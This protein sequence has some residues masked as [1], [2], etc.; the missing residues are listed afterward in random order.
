MN[1]LIVRLLTLFIL[2]ILVVFSFTPIP[3]T[4]LIMLYVVLFRPRWFK[5][6]VDLI[7]AEARKTGQDRTGTTV[8]SKSTLE[9]KP[10]GARHPPSSQGTDF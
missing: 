7:Y 1:P 5:H 2:S 3:G 9:K 8:E 6:L 4:T 10:A